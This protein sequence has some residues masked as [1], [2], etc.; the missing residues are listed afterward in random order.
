MEQIRK[1]KNKI[2]MNNKHTKGDNNEQNT[3][4][5]GNFRDNECWWI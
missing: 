1:Q 4:N 2:R 5:R 3:N